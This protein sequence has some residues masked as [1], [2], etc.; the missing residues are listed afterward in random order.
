MWIISQN[1]KEAVNSN[2]IALLKVEK[3]EHTVV[4]ETYRTM[5]ELGAYQ[6]SDHAEQVLKHIVKMMAMAKTEEPIKMPK[7]WPEKK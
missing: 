3:E 2:N 6:N 1:G 7:I 5:I 4:A